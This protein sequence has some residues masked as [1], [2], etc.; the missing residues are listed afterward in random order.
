MPGKHPSD[1]NRFGGK[2]SVKK[3]EC[4]ECYLDSY[5]NVMQNQRWARLW[6][7]DAFSGDGYQSFRPEGPSETEQLLFDESK[8]SIEEFTEGSAMRAVGLS[9]GRESVEKRSF[10]H[11]VFLE[12]DESK[13]ASLKNRIAIAYPDQIAKCQF[14]KGDVNE[15]LPLL[16]GGL[17]WRV[18]RAVTFIDPCAT[19]LDWN[20]IQCFK[21]TCSDVWLLFPLMGIIRMLPR[22]G[23]PSDGWSKKLTRIF[24]SST[25]NE[26]YTDRHHE[27]LA[28]FGS[29]DP[30]MYRSGGYREL[31]SYATSRYK[32]VFS[33]VN[34][35]AVLKTE[36]NAP[37][38]ALYS[39][40]ANESKR[41][42]SRSSA[43][44]RHLRKRLEE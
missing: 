40:V 36:K 28:L 41:A 34:G 30:E 20:T 15:T 2:W 39:M 27:Q 1:E 13:I 21:G 12:Y 29:E 25:W 37:L 33:E 16:L 18:D 19:Q 35:P 6:Y 3:L 5:L 26:M 43:I 31:L 11:F 24:G 4:V 17:D 10:D 7:I 22:E 14:S 38:F 23:L 32:T 8:A 44:S 9:S 42:R